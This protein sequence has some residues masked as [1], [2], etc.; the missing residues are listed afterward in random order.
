MTN[1]GPKLILTKTQKTPSALEGLNHEDIIMFSCQVNLST[2][3]RGIKG[4]EKLKRPF[5]QNCTYLEH[6]VQPL[7]TSITID[8]HHRKIFI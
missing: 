5:K 6:D 8:V 7:H 4:T 3:N 2:L 1:F